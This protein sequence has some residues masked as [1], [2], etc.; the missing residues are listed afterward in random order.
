V[1]FEQFSWT[2]HSK[3]NLPA[4]AQAWQYV[5]D[6]HPIL[7]TAFLWEDIDEPLQIVRR[8]VQPPLEQHDWRALSSDDQEAQ[9]EAF[10][11][12]DRRR[13]FDLAE[14]PLMR[15]TLLQMREDTYHI[16][17]SYHHLLLDGWSIPLILKDVF[18][19]VRGV[20]PGPVSTAGTPA[21]VPRLYHV[22]APAE[23]DRGREIL[24][25][26]GRTLQDHRPYATGCRSTIE[27][28]AQPRRRLCDTADVPL[29]GPRRRPCRCW[30]SSSG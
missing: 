29:S 8:H 9:L 26:G 2:I 11:K 10:L 28:R 23:S 14:A 19:R 6:Q 27:K 7:R 3:L 20:L 5:V 12:A 22:A 18:R 17:W 13:G 24:A 25:G 4:F 1:Y 21:A 16:V 30:P 15:L